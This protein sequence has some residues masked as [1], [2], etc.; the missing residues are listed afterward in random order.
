MSSQVHRTLRITTVLVMF[1]VLAAFDA[2]ACPMVT[3]P[4]VQADLTEALAEI[5]GSVTVAEGE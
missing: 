3:D 4:T 1:V 5:E 2:N